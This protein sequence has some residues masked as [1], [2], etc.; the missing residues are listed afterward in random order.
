MHAS[1]AYI[2][3]QGGKEALE[4]GVRMRLGEFTKCIY[5]RGILVIFVAH[6]QFWKRSLSYA[7]FH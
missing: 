2:H 1:A 5:I 4:D 7:L 6:H 3:K